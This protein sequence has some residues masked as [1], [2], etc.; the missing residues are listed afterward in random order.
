M[1]IISKFM[2]P[3][4]A[5]VMVWLYLSSSAQPAIATQT[6]AH[7]GGKTLIVSMY[8]PALGGI[9]CAHPCDTTATG[10]PVAE[11]YKR[12]AAC[13][14]QWTRERRTVYVPQ[15]GWL[16]CIDNGGAI[17]EDAATAW[18]DIL[19]PAAEFGA[20]PYRY[21]DRI[22]AGS[23]YWRTS[24]SETVVSLPYHTEAYQTGTKGVHDNG[25]RD[26][27]TDAGCGAPLFAP[28]TGTV[29][30]VGVDGMGNTYVRM[31]DG[32]NDVLMMHGDYVVGVGD[33]IQRGQTLIGHENTH[34][35]SSHCHTHFQW[36]KY[37]AAVD[38]QILE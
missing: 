3:L 4:A 38:P 23:W 20:L 15:V 29:T 13:P 5:A 7:S 19:W 9:N 36:I 25:A 33:H 12:G 6:N 28:L 35:N 30:E 8:D 34:G 17:V 31:S 11:W 32:T 14:Q 18:V 26:Y 22:P 16:E 1:K 21:G 37:G 10:R 27:M 2:L 24:Q